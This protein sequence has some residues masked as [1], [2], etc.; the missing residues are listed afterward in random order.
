M[1]L[2]EKWQKKI[3]KEKTYNKQKSLGMDITSNRISLTNKIYNI[4]TEVRIID[5][6]D[7]DGKAKGTRVLIDIPKSENLY[8]GQR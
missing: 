5:L 7:K 4:N 1:A 2:G 6:Y 8:I 3:K